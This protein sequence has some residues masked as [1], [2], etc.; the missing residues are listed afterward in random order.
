MIK[1]IWIFALI[2]ILLFASAG[3]WFFLGKKSETGTSPY[4]VIPQDASLVLETDNLHKFIKELGVKNRIWE[5][6]IEI[7]SFRKLDKEV[8][9]LDSLI[10]SNKS[11]NN[12][13]SANPLIITFHV[14]GKNQ[15]Q[16]L[17]LLN[18]SG[19]Y[20]RPN[21]LQDLIG[22]MFAS[23]VV[24]HEKIYHKIKI[25]I[26]ES[27]QN[28]QQYFFAVNKGVLLFSRSDILLESA[29]R[30]ADLNHGF[31]SES[32][33][34]TVKKSAG[35]NV[36]A[37]LYVNFK[38]LGGFL[39]PVF[40]KKYRAALES[41]NQ[42]ADWAELDVNIEENQILLNGF[43]CINKD[44]NRYLQIFKGQSV[45]KPQMDQILPSNTIT[46]FEFTL[47][48]FKKYYKAYKTF[49]LETGKFAAYTK[50]LNQLKSG[51]KADPE[52]LFIPFIEKEIGVSYTDIKNI[53]TRENK[54]VLI[55][56][57]SVSR[58]IDELNKVLKLIPGHSG[59]S[60]SGYLQEIKVDQ[61]T[62]FPVYHL[63]VKNLPE[64]LFGKIFGKEP[65]QY[66]TFVESY[67]VFGNSKSAL[68]NFVHNYVLQ[69]N[70]NH[71]IEYSNFKE[72]LALKS[73]FF[74]YSDPASSPEIMDQVLHPDL[75]EGYHKNLEI[76]RKIQALG[77][78]FSI[79][80]DLIYNNLIIKYR[81]VYKE[82]ASTQW[83]SLLDTTLR[84]KPALVVNHY[85]REKE[86]FI[87]D[88]KNNIYLINT[89][90]RVLWKLRL[91]EKIMSEIYQIDYYKNGKLQLLFNTKN[92]LHLIDRNG[93]YVEK[94][95]IGLR[96]PATNG[97]A[98]FDYDKTRDY[99]ICI[100]GSDKK[101]YLYDKE[102]KTIKGWSN[103]KTES[104]LNSM[105]KYFKIDTKDYIVYPD[106]LKL[107]IV[108]RKGKIRIDIKK[109]IP[110]AKHPNIVVIKEPS[111]F[112][113]VTNSYNGTVFYINKNGEVE[114][115]TFGTFSPEHF[116]TVEDLNGDHR[117]EYIFIDH[118]KLF[119]FHS[120]GNPLFD[121]TFSQ[122]ISLEPV[123]YTF[124]S[125]DRKIGI[126]SARAHK[127]FLFNNDGE[128][129]KNFP[130]TGQTL[131]SIGKF[132]STTAG[133]NLIVGGENNF[134]YNYFVEYGN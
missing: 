53:P 81:P 2:V 132:R 120:S 26:I 105:V 43:S 40:D 10:R 108:N 6:L 121:Y 1:R 29:L 100:A 116:F 86:I 33:F 46:F 28:D 44:K 13:V 67:L 95:P 131:F 122:D 123:I 35:R 76:I 72:S 115:K 47:S 48:D 22:K 64:T 69:K 16:S 65:F 104:V 106:R 68:S 19:R 93:N 71:Q 92:Y 74:F 60:S 124:S 119:V 88:E 85:T 117:N 109:N 73:N 5:N 75:K 130:L 34:L 118:N 8:Q 133:F 66:L 15:I 77:F 98:L 21:V 31:T 129:Y 42:F 12:I 23:G 37:N 113:W 101:I 39:N 4:T 61:Q 82:R 111:G 50:R 55:K 90:G 30:Q 102:G 11:L 41:L 25:K 57:K 38:N 62:R 110:K 27:S 97:M 125:N 58:F 87:Q 52:K 96:S 78:Q 7:N 18:I 107:F 54:F 63:P 45:E 127:I 79:D 89:A 134:L 24:I 32:S 91:P 20:A 51:L 114:K 126:V 83:E 56:L 17:F 99:R 112:K 49:L 80:N 14:T 70:L 84:S 128:V 59:T 9:Y 94:Y 36:D 3:M 103:P